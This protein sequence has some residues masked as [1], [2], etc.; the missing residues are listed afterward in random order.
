VAKVYK[1][2]QF[3]QERYEVAPGVWQPTFEQYD[4]DGRKFM[5]PFSIHERTFYS[6]YKRVGPPEEAVEVV[7]AELN[8]LQADRGS[9]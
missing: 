5:V 2:S 6:N 7:R 4:F 9:R 3:M 1:G 8:K